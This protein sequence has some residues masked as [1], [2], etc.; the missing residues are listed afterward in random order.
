MLLPALS[1][2]FLRGTNGLL[3]LFAATALLVAVSIPSQAAAPHNK[4]MSMAKPGTPIQLVPEALGTYEWQI[5]TD[6]P[7]A[8]AFFNQGMQLRWAYNMPESVASMVRARELDPTCAMCFWGEAFSRG[9]FL[10]GGMS[11]EQAAAARVA[12][13]QANQLKADCSPCLL[14]T[15]PSPR[16]YAASRMPSSA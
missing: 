11:A 9:S 15:S 4:H 7:E 1:T 16:D 6:S 5:S 8:Q 10:N 13:Q 14:Y 12:I 2:N 3:T